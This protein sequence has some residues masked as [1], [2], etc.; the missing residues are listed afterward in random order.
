[1]KKLTHYRKCQPTIEYVG[2]LK[3]MSAHSKK[4]RHT[5]EKMSVHYMNC[6]CTIKIFAPHTSNIY[7]IYKHIYKD[8]HLL[9]VWPGKNP[10]VTDSSSVLEFLIK[11]SL[12]ARNRVGTG[13]SYRHSRAGIFKC[14]RS[15][16]IDSASLCSLA[17][18]YNNPFLLGS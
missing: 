4:C 6:R 3:K 18:R 11:Q 7:V 1:M 5:T 17:G 14:L 10:M 2:E 12:G 16:G 9:T 15:S 13:L 8:Q